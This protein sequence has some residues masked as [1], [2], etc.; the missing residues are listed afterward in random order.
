MTNIAFIKHKVKII[1]TKDISHNDTEQGLMVMVM[2]NRVVVE[3]VDGLEVTTT[4]N[5]DGELSSIVKRHNEVS[6]CENGPA[7]VFFRGGRVR[8]EIWFVNGHRHRDDGPA[9]TVYDED[10]EVCRETWFHNGWV[11]LSADHTRLFARG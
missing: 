10:G 3:T 5:E 8:R 6:H 4:H 11:D 1:Y 9:E 2:G 7:Q